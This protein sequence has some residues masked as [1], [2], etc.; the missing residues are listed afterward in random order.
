MLRRCFAQSDFFIC[1]IRGILFIFVLGF[2]GILL[3]DEFIP[4]GGIYLIVVQDFRPIV[5]FILGN[6]NRI[7]LVVALDRY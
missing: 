6:G 1:R 7:P 2:N 5:V 3:E 4:S